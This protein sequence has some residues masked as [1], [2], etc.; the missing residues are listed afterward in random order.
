MK[1][2]PVK[3]GA[4]ITAHR[5]AEW[6]PRDPLRS[7][8]A[9]ASPSTGFSSP[10]PLSTCPIPSPS[11]APILRADGNRARETEEEDLGT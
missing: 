8:Y 2:W 5:G 10:G 3:C 6:A 9:L 7:T 4:K 11:K 1:I